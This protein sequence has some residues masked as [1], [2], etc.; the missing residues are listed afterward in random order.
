MRANKAQGEAECDTPTVQW[1]GVVYEKDFRAPSDA[2][3]LQRF[4]C[5]QDITD[6]SQSSFSIDI[7]TFPCMKYFYRTHRHAK[8]VS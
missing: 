4:T 5:G 7:Y 6:P 3:L 8:L 2:F 1:E